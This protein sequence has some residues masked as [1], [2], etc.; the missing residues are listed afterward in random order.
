VIAL[1]PA[2][3]GQAARQQAQGV[4]DRAIHIGRMGKAAALLNMAPDLGRHARGGM[5]LVIGQSVNVGGIA[6]T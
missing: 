1:L 2:Q 3:I 5:A 6:L 4:I